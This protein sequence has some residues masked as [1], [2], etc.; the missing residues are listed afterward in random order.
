MKHAIIVILL[1]V[2]GTLCSGEEL[3]NNEALEALEALDLGTFIKTETGLMYNISLSGKGNKPASGDIVTVH[4]TG[5]LEDGTKFD[6]SYDRNEPIS[7]ELGVGRVIKG[8][9]E[10]IALLKK[11]GKATL[12]IP[13]ELAYGS[14]GMGPIPPSATLIFEVELIDFEPAPTIEEYDIE[15]KVVSTT[16]SGLQFI[17]VDAGTGKKAAAGNTVRVHYS[18]YL[19]DGSMFDSSVKRNQPFEFVLGMGRVIPGWDE[20]VAL[21]REGDKVRFIIPSELGYGAAGAG[22]V[23]PPNADLI[24][25]VEL[26]EVK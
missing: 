4:Y 18:G 12:I 2:A 26:L 5:T 20:G 15:G 19:K 14:R 7:F 1:F 8:W 16:E 21:M 3:S 10:G 25:D 22:G 13:P 17:L 11:G 23:I 9:D 6:S 24:F